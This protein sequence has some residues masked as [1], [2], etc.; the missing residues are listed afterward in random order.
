MAL[1]NVWRWQD[2][3]QRPD[4]RLEFLTAPPF[5]VPQIN[6]PPNA[7]AL[8]LQEGKAK[9]V[10]LPK[11]PSRQR[12]R[13]ILIGFGFDPAE[14][15]DMFDALPDEPEPIRKEPKSAVRDIDPELML[16]QLRAADAQIEKDMAAARGDMAT[17]TD[18]SPLAEALKEAGRRHDLLR[19]ADRLTGLLKPRITKPD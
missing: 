11:P 6:L 17:P 8:T 14:F 15:E 16:M 18:N 9:G 2:P 12:M 1:K 7:P 19:D 10:V 5:P 3:Q 13:S 4:V